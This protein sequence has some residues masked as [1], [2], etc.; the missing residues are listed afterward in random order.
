MTQRLATHAD[1]PD[2]RQRVLEE[3]ARTL[4]AMSTTS[5]D[6]RERME[7]VEFSLGQETYGLAMTHVRE[8]APVRD[9]TPLPGSPPFVLGIINVR[10]RI[11][12]VV[13]LGKFFDLPPR[14]LSDLNRAIVLCH[15]DME[16]A[17]MADAVVGV[18]TLALDEL[19][20]LPAT[21]TGIRAAFSR[22]IT[23]DSLVVL[24]AE[25]ILRDRALIAHDTMTT[26]DS[27]PNGG[28][29]ERS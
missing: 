18:R 21:L 3:R 27:R 5:T 28:H 29:L 16:F 1:S 25:K 15:G 2:A 12:S 4:A 13:E 22:G 23:S 19:Q 17:V 24:D 10:G 9:Y 26:S 20:P 7:V 6:R 8:V 11:V 14:G